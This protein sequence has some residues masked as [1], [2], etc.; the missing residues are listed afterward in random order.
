MYDAFTSGDPQKAWEETQRLVSMSHQLQ[1]EAAT[2]R[3]KAN[4][5][6]EMCTHCDGLKAGPD[7]VATCF[8]IRQCYFTNV[9]ART[10]EKHTRL[11]EKLSKKPDGDEDDSNRQ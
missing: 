10:D 11:I 7:V 1:K 2:A 6:T 4:F 8:Q 3:F 5:G 9:R